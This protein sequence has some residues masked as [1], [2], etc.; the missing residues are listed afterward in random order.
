MQDMDLY[1]GRQN[2]YF[3]PQFDTAD[4]D[5]FSRMSDTVQHDEV[6]SRNKATRLI[7]FVAAMCIVSFTAGLMIGIKFAGG[8]DKA[9][10]D[11]HTKQAMSNLGQKV[12]G[13]TAAQA[14]AAEP[15]ASAKQT[16]AK[17][18]YPW[19]IRIGN[20]YSREKAGEVA[21]SLSQK[22]HTMVISKYEQGYRV[23]AGPFRT[24]ESAELSLQKIR[25]YNDSRW[26]KN[27]VILKR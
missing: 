8:S 18:E 27:T 10:V 22:G 1:T 6:K 26:Q 13:I 15:S 16:Y 11:P 14:E 12:A 9:L 5:Y 21:G 19:V 7:A 4:P 25:A 2:G 24:R 20:E 17:G 23:Y 3:V